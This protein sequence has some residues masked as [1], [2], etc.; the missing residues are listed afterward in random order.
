MKNKDMFYV[1]MCGGYYD[2]FKTPKQLTVVNGEAIV[3]RTIR[4]LNSHGIKNIYISSNDK[5]FDNHNALRL[6]HENSYK[7]E[8]GI[9][10][11]YWLD[12]FYPNFTPEIK[13]C[14][15]FGDVYYTE[16]AID[17][18][19]NTEV[20]ENTLFGSA[21][22]KNELHKNWG[23]PFAYTVVDYPAFMNGVK[24]VKKAFDEG[25]LDRHPLVWELYRYLN[26]LDLNV[27]QVIDKTFIVIDD[28]TTDI[29]APW[30]EEDLN[31]RFS[32]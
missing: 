18:I 1:I 30:Q 15:L 17:K 8:N 23:E 25:K 13:V 10:Y 21:M 29:D 6:E 14:F 32:G 4:L 19:V 27:Q 5:R 9:L 16:K 28:G 31:K 20:T 3:D 26:G 11:G 12:A 22:A 2:T 24:E 7:S